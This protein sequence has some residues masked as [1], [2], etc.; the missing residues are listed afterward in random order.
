MLPQEGL[1][2]DRTG[3]LPRG[4]VWGVSTS[5]YQIEGAETEDGRG[6]SN[7]D[8]FTRQPGRIANGDTGARSD[9]R[10]VAEQIVAGHFVPFTSTLFTLSSANATLWCA[11]RRSPHWRPPL[12]RNLSTRSQ[13]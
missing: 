2:E 8:A 11:H 7:W 6:P 9:F 4:F 10:L 5:S 3:A 1:A 12:H 13:R